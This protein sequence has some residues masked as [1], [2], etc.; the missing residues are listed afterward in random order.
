MSFK[1]SGGK[2]RGSGGKTSDTY[3]SARGMQT[4]ERGESDVTSMHMREGE[5]NQSLRKQGGKKS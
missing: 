4:R 3:K 2:G 1:G 5:R